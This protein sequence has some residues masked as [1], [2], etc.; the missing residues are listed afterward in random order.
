MV[1]NQFSTTVKTI[2]SDNG[3]EFTS[4][5]TTLFFQSK[6]I[7]H[8]KSCPYTPQQN[9]VV[10]RKHK[11]ILETARALLFQSKLLVK[12]W[13]ECILASTCLINR[14]PSFPL[15]NKTPYEILYKHKPIYS[16]LKSFGCLCYPTTPKVHRTKFDPK[17]IPHVFVGY[18]YATKG[19][20]VLNLST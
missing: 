17:T 9:G 11:Y 4:N 8:Q 7:I 19:Y 12:Y 5:E 6:G 13:G 3:L 18:P 2:R 1:E 15:H 16:H 20:K 10:E 14:L